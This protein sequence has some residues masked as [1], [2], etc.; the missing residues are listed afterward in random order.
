VYTPPVPALKLYSAAAIKPPVL[1]DVMDIQDFKGA[2]VLVHDIPP[3][4]RM[5]MMIK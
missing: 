1:L 5:M 3:F 2:D 4:I